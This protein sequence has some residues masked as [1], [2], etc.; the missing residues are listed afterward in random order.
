MNQ[1]ENRPTLAEVMGTLEELGA[2]A[3]AGDADRYRAAVRLAQR[4]QI[5]EEQQRD[6]YTWGRRGQG[7]ARS[8]NWKGE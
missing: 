3:R 2:A 4:Q 7:A 5:T 6:A 8:F 1:Q